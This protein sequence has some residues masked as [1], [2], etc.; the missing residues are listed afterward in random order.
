MPTLILY[1]NTENEKRFPVS[2]GQFVIGSSEDSTVRLDEETVSPHH[3]R[4][5]KRGDEFFI[6]D[7]K[8]AG[9][10]A[11]NGARM[12]EAC[13][14]DGDLIQLGEV[15]LLFV[16]RQAGEE[17]LAP[18]PIQSGVVPSGGPACPNCGK[19]TGAGVAFC[20]WC[21]C[22]LARDEFLPG[23]VFIGPVERTL[24]TRGAGILPMISYLLG[25]FGP[26]IFGIGWLLAIIL[27]F[28]SLSIIRKR[29]GLASD[30]RK[31]MLGIQF[32][33][34]WA[35]VGCIAGGVVLYRRHQ[36]SVAL[37]IAVQI[38]QNELG[39]KNS[40]RDIALTQEYVKS[41]LLF[42]R[43]Q[44]G[45]SEYAKFGDLVEV[46]F[47]YSPPTEIQDEVIGGYRFAL[48]SAGEEDFLCEAI[49]AEYRRTGIRSFS[50]GADGYL[51]AGDIGGNGISELDKAL[52][53]LSDAPVH[54]QLAE[55]LAGNLLR[56][57]EVKAKEGDYL[58]SK[59]IIEHIRSRYPVTEAQK[60]LDGLAEVVDPFIIEYRSKEL[61]ET[62]HA[63]LDGGDDTRA[64]ALLKE[65]EDSFPTC[66]LIDSVKAMRSQAEGK[67]QERMGSEARELSEAARTAYQKGDYE[68]ALKH[69]RQ[70][71]REYTSTDYYKKNEALL[72]GFV[73]GSE[74][75][76]AGELLAKM[77]SLSPEKDY[78]E[79]IRIIEIIRS[80]Y[81]DTASVKANASS[82]DSMVALCSA[83]GV[84]VLGEKELAAGNYRN[85]LA[86][87]EEAVEKNPD[88]RRAM[89]RTLETTHLAVGNMDHEEKNY[90]SALKHYEQYLASN[91][92]GGE[93]APGR[94]EDAYYQ[95]GRID[96]ETKNLDGAEE[97]LLKAGLYFES[98]ADFNFLLAN[99]LVGNKRYK[100]AVG[101]YS[102]SIDIDGDF[103]E[104]YKRR[105]LSS[106]GAA[107]QLEDEI[108]TSE[109]DLTTET[110]TLFNDIAGL[111]SD[112]S[113]KYRELEPVL[114]KARY[115]S[116]RSKAK[117]IKH[118][119]LQG[120]LSQQQK[121]RDVL[122]RGND[123]NKHIVNTVRR[124]ESN[125]RA[126]IA[127]LTRVAEAGGNDFRLDK[128][129][130]MAVKKLDLVK[131]ARV[132]LAPALMREI[133]LRN[134]AFSL[135]D[136]KMEQYQ[137][138]MSTAGIEEASIVSRIL[139]SPEIIQIRK[140]VFDGQGLLEDAKEIEVKVEEY[141]LTVDEYVSRPRADSGSI[142]E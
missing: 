115:Q 27:G 60:Q 42:D 96:Y 44:D 7:L 131:Q 113:Q 14:R 80:G 136:R 101:Y 87:L 137:K 129:Q 26:L 1:P 3:A 40:L 97:N 16:A 13:L 22:Q 75:A 62:A 108:D 78:E 49:P 133:A 29:G 50:I 34:G 70:I 140:M 111:V 39:A 59:K 47:P 125:L 124:M 122:K 135:L 104:A 109:L 17:L 21:G 138:E 33:L 110:K 123:R 100:D 86:Y 58:G 61:Y 51:R 15:E 88:L 71:Q 41:G 98:N 36:R 57:A 25:I 93:L 35:V 8:S 139:D 127:D 69:Y 142:E 52:Q 20:P 18:V 10:I 92:E 120:F 28:A 55:E 4:I 99:V 38:E 83:H 121:F 76:L 48:L 102:R 94:L 68:E 64:L 103:Q 56:L 81:A 141:L 112:M 24:A 43:D 119:H 85:A 132:L 134:E 74:E 79:I 2:G 19:G 72:Q 31:A 54:E 77:R 130:K 128:L 73:K 11:V 116:T 117:R 90:R 6:V 32:G 126:G 89:K 23:E 114:K 63:A 107:L 84:R 30:R 9:G 46:D 12:P 65:V 91:P 105:G 66:S 53:V 67:I 118:S 5:E 106:I 95:L 45:I 37:R 82:L